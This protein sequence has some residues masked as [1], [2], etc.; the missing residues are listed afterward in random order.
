MLR[1]LL[2]R[3]AIQVVLAV[4]LFS[5]A[6]T[7]QSED[8]QSVAAAAR[9][10]REQKKTAVKP[11]R[12]FTDEDIKPAAPAGSEPAPAQAPTAADTSN[13][14]AAPANAAA[15]AA[16]GLKD[17]K[18]AKEL[19]EVKALIKEIQSD[20][21]LLQRQQSLEQDSYFSNPDYVHDTAGKAKLD[22]LKQ[23]ASDKQ[24][25]LERLKARLAELQPAPDTS[26]IPP[27]KT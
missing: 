2:L 9:R 16:P 4:T 21:D 13:P 14:P 12:V 7:A 6:A 25:D 20:I 27:P 17:E 15:P 3:L 10:A 1:C 18:A 8:T 23:Q 5:A 11:A 22:A 19:A 26:T 24:L